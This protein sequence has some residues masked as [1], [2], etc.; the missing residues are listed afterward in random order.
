LDGIGSRNQRVSYIT[1]I[2]YLQWRAFIQ[3][4]PDAQFNLIGFDKSLLS[5][6]ADR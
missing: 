4:H 2:F 1:W 3:K 6:E 5:K